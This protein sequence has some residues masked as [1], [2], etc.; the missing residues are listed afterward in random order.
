[1][2]KKR[3]FI[4]NNCCFI[5]KIFHDYDEVYYCPLFF[6]Q[7]QKDFSIERYNS[8][9]S[10]FNI[11]WCEDFELLENDRVLA[12]NCTNE[13]NTFGDKLLPYQNRLFTT[14]DFE[15]GNSFT[16]FRKKAEKRLPDYFDDA[17]TPIDK[18]VIKEIDYY[19][20]NDS[21]PLNYFDT[22]N[23][24][25]GRDYST[26]FSPYLSSGVLDPRYI[27]NRV[28]E[29]ERK[30]SANKSTYWIIFELLWRDFFFWNYH[31]NVELFFS[32]NGIKGEKDFSSFKRYNFSELKEI[33]NSNFFHAS[34]NELEATGYLSNRIRQIFASF[35]INDLNLD[36]RSGASLFEEHLIDY[37]VFSNYGN[38]L[39]LSGFGCD[40]RGKRYFNVEKQLAIY[41][42]NGDYLKKWL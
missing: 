9:K 36:W 42:K 12:W 7:N 41:D 32:K 23:G 10:L 30:V 16:S 29:F 8:L 34:L 35:W 22:R 18:N 28:K 17:I 11:N 25:V 14:L 26:K 4:L 24:V 37:D 31:S 2:I 6:S 13:V 39:Y 33:S 1:M 38:W 19:F 40:P 27:Y 15:V 5:E 20:K 3:L 21:L